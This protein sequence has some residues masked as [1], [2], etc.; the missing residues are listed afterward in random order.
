MSELG[1][2]L[3]SCHAHRKLDTKALFAGGGLVAG[4]GQGGAQDLLHGAGEAEPG[5]AVVAG[6]VADRGQGV[7][8]GV[9]VGVEALHP[10]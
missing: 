7:R 6:G 4:G 5:P 10:V 2:S 9:V 1:Q 3:V 8:H